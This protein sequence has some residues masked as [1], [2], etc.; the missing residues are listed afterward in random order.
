MVDVAEIESLAMKWDVPYVAT[1]AK[2]GVGVVEAFETLVRDVEKNG[3]MRQS[4]PAAT[5]MRMASS[6]CVIH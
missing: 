6:M 2:D 4:R 3:S 1:S 5:K